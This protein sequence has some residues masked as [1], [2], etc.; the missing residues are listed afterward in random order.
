[1][2][3]RVCDEAWDGVWTEV[4]L[5]KL[6]KR[7][8]IYA[9]SEVDHLLDGLNARECEMVLDILEQ[10]GVID[11]FCIV[12]KDCFTLRGLRARDPQYRRFMSQLYEKGVISTKTL[13]DSY[14]TAF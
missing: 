1:M 12:V 14:D 9:G 8:P 2:N 6:E 7:L 3:D 4:L 13:L 10:Q 5:H 11:D